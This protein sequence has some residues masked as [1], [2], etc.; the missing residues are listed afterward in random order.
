[1]VVNVVN[2]FNTDF[3]IPI[4]MSDENM[5]RAHKRGAILNEKFWFNKNFIQS[6]NYWESSLHKSDFTESKTKDSER[7][8]P[9]YEEFYLHE[10]LVGK[11]NSDFG[12]IYP[13]I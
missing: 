3:I 2:H 7:I 1:M 13:V 12:G 5:L 11:K 4:S 10:I 8:E 6:E 9:E